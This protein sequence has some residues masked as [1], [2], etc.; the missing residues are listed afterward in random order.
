[1][2][3]STGEKPP[4]TIRTFELK[5]EVPHATITSIA[6]KLARIFIKRFKV[7]HCKDK[8]KEGFDKIPVIIKEKQPERGLHK[9]FSIIFGMN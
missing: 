7:F 2:N 1:M 9:D 4:F 3:T 5:N 8:N 6:P